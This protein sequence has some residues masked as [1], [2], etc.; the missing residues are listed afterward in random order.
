MSKRNATR[1]QMLERIF[2]IETA[3]VIDEYS[4]YE[5]VDCMSHEPRACPF[6]SVINKDTLRNGNFD[7]RYVAND[8][9]PI[10]RA[11]WD[12]AEFYR[13]RLKNPG[14]SYRQL[15]L[16]E[17]KTPNKTPKSR[18]SQSFCVIQ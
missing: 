13:K 11:C 14:A 12:C 16:H 7:T 10:C 17:K 9:D 3:R 8:G 1:L 4:K 18:K 15:M 5:T 6:N 2:P